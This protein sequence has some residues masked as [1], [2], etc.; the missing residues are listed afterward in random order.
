MLAAGTVQTAASR[1]NWSGVARRISACR[2]AVSTG[3]P[4]GELGER[5]ARVD[6]PQRGADL[7]EVQRRVVPDRPG[8]LRQVGEYDRHGVVIRPEL[9]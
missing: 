8:A 5:G 4:H 2:A 7:G 9:A 1:S 3:Q 6:P